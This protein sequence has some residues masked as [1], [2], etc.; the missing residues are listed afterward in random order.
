M[1][2]YV[3]KY[4]QFLTINV[5]SNSLDLRVSFGFYDMFGPRSS[6]FIRIHVSDIRMQTSNDIPNICLITIYMYITYFNNQRWKNTWIKWIWYKDQLYN[7]RYIFSWN[8][9]IFYKFH[10]TYKLHWIQCNGILF[11]QISYGRIRKRSVYN[12][13]EESKAK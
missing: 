3:Y 8:Q 2:F 12:I 6:H 10:V 11:H 9:M 7:G 5:Y 1:P 13:N 4:C